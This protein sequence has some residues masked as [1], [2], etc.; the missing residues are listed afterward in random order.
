L[1]QRGIDVTTAR[2][3][4]LI[5]ATDTAH[6]AFATGQER[7]LMTHDHDFL[8]LHAQSTSHAGIAYCHQ[9]KYRV[10]ELIRLLV[11]LQTCYRADD[12]KGRVE[13]L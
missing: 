1:R 11:L 3:A 8:R 12:M 5:G 6:L 2:D 13:F 4:N 7:V 10:G 9:D